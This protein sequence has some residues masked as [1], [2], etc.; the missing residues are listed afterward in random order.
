MVLNEKLESN[1]FFIVNKSVSTEF[2]LY[3]KQENLIKLD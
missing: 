2:P 1:N 3:F